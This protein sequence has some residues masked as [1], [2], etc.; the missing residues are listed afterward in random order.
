[1]CIVHTLR[2]SGTSSP[3]QELL[4][5]GPDVDDPDPALPR[6]VDARPRVP[7]RR[8]VGAFWEAGAVVRVRVPAFSNVNIYYICYFLFIADYIIF[9]LVRK[10]VK[11][12]PNIR[13]TA[14]LL[15]G[16]RTRR[17]TLTGACRPHRPAAA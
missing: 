16:A 3:S 6:D 1:V 11:I 10:Q 14:M 5:P 4:N 8:L 7:P 9:K 13:K 2:A 15:A 17:R 12:V